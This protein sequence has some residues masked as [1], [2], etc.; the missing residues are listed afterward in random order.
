[1]ILMGKILKVIGEFESDNDIRKVL[2]KFISAKHQD[3]LETNLN[4]MKKGADYED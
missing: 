2:Q 1:M 3:M 4:V